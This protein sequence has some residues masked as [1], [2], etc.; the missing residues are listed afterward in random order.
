[1]KIEKKNVKKYE[2]TVK[3]TFGRRDVWDKGGGRITKMVV[4]TVEWKN[5]GWQ[6][7][8]PSDLCLPLFFYYFVVSSS[9]EKFSLARHKISKAFPNVN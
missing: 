6:S 4:W 1:M 5:N 9:S 7:G 3:Y 2:R 8:Q